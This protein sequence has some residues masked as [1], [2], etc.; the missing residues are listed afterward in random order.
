VAGE[1]NRYAA[2]K[3]QKR[4]FIMAERLAVDVSQTYESGFLGKR[5]D[6]KFPCTGARITRV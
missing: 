5:G 3:Q 2:S 6:D 4:R 1:F